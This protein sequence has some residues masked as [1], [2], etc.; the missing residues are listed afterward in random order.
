MVI[1]E[2]CN[3]IA[4]TIYDGLPLCD[5]HYNHFKSNRKPEVVRQLNSIP[6]I[7]C[8]T[9][10]KRKYMNL[11][12]GF[13]TNEEYLTILDDFKRDVRIVKRKTNFYNELT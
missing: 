9:V 13:T 5:K 12:V 7:E 8:E 1:C 11:I 3:E 6:I 2:H 4:I 10:F